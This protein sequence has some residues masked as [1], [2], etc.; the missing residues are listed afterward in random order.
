MT[1][2]KLPVP[3]MSPSS[4]A[5]SSEE[6]LFVQQQRKMEQTKTVRNRMLNF[7]GLRRIE[8]FNCIP[9]FSHCKKSFTIALFA[10]FNA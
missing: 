6:P 8:N 4:N 10:T 9:L 5:Q 3:P 1:L 7:Y 2:A